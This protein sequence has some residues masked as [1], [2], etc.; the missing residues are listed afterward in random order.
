M[1]EVTLST[2]LGVFAKHRLG[3]NETSLCLESYDLE[4]VLFDIY[5]AA[6]KR[7]KRNVDVDFAVELMQNFLYNIY[8]RYDSYCQILT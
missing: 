5:F 3:M 1:E 4:A 8:D 6:N 7:N 2:V